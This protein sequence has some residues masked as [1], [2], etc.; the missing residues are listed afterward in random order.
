MK[1]LPTAPDKVLSFL[2]TAA[3]AIQPFN[4]LERIH[5]QLRKMCKPIPTANRMPKPLWTA[6]GKTAGINPET[7]CRTNRIASSGL[8]YF[9]TL[10]FDM[11]FSSS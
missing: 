10:V 9:N 1:K 4:R 3:D 6:Y 2:W 11:P 5:D 7:N 8:R